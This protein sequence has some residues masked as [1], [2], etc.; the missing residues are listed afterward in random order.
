MTPVDAATLVLALTL[1]MLRIMSRELDKAEA[2]DLRR[3]GIVIVR[4]R[5]LEAHSQPIGEYLGHEIWQTVTFRGMVYDFS[6]VQPAAQRESLS[7]GE[8]YLEPGLVYVT[9]RG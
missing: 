6:R 9:G 3:H 7:P 8:L 2:L 5:V 1:G 4:E